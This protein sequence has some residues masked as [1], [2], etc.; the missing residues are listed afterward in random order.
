M[1]MLS[2]NRAVLS[3][4][5]TPTRFKTQGWPRPMPTMIRPSVSRS[6]TAI[7]LARIAGWCRG[8]VKSQGKRRAGEQI[9][10]VALGRRKKVIAQFVGNRDL[11]QD[12]GVGLLL[13][14]TGIRKFRK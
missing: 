11:L 3:A 1:R 9:F 5:L 14:L 4:G 13:R 6:A 8:N 12:F 7:S 10:A 2:S